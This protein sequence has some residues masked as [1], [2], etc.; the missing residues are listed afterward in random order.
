M[1]ITR[2]LPE[3]QRH[4]SR[5]E[6]CLEAFKADY[7]HHWRHATRPYPGIPTLLETLARRALPCAVVTN[8]P[9]AF[10]DRCV[11]HFFPQAPFRIVVGQQD[12]RPLKPHPRPALAAADHLGVPPGACL[13]IGDSD[14]DMATAQAAGMLP[15]GAAWGF[16]SAGEL[17]RA[18]AAAVVREP[19]EVLPWIDGK[20]TA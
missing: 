16:R 5:I 4:P 17:G 14:V 6:A 18:G 3:G 15:L 8:K 13:L 7:G 2:A 1:L 9:Q 11:N 20:H 10:A 12:G 19:R